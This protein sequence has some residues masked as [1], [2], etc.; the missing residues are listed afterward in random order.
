MHNF[1]RAVS[2]PYEIDFQAT[3]EW[4]H[5]NNIIRIKQYKGKFCI[6]IILTFSEVFVRS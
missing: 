4:M 6:K 5:Y 1:S 2:F 3:E